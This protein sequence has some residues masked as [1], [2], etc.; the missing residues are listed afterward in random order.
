V[1]GATDLP[2]YVYW[3]GANADKSVD[4]LQVVQGMS[5]SAGSTGAAACLQYLEA[6]KSVPNF[7]G[8]KFTDT[9]FYLFQQL[10]YHAPSILG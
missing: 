5:H 3:V 8:V 6:M 4:A 2:F 1:G 7:R 10:R 9:N